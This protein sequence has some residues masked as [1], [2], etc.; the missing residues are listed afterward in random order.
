MYEPV[1]I[2]VLCTKLR[3][4]GTSSPGLAKFSFTAGKTH[5]L[6]LINPSSSGS[7]ILF[8]IDNHGLTIIAN[9]FT[10]V[11]RSS[12]PV[13]VQD[14]LNGAVT[15]ERTVEQV[16]YKTNVVSIGVSTLPWY[17]IPHFTS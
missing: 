3:P 2:L 12:F 13:S 5:R 15:E 6:R 1:L 10:P 8:S 16:P 17:I 14:L 11:V 7:P 4:L 9:D